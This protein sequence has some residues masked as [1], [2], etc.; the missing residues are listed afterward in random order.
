MDVSCRDR[1]NSSRVLNPEKCLR[2]VRTETDVSW[3]SICLSRGV[4]VT[5]RNK[6][7]S[8]PSPTGAQRI[9]SRLK[10]RRAKRPVMCDMVPGWL[11]TRKSRMMEDIMIDSFSFNCSDE[12]VCARYA[13]AK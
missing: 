5:R 13:V 7:L 10:A 2:Q 4:L 3:H 12:W 8:E 11:R 1:R 6:R 9:A